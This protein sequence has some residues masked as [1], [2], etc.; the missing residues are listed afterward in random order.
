[1]NSLMTGL[2]LPAGIIGAVISESDAVVHEQ[3]SVFSF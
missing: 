3:F 1:L 2:N